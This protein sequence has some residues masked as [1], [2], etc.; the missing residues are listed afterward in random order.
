MIDKL[1]GIVSPHIC[2]GCKEKGNTLCDSC[3]FNIIDDSYQKCIACGGLAK[4]GNLCQKCHSKMPFDRA[5]V[6]GERR[7]ELKRLVG[8]FKYNSER[9]GA[10]SVAKLLDGV[11]PALPHGTVIVPIPTIAPHIRQRGF[12]HMELV[13]RKL[14]RIRKMSY[15]SRLLIRIDNSV[16]HGLTLR[17]REKRAAKTFGVNRH[18]SAPSEVLLIDDIY[19]SGHTMIAATKLLKKA[20]VKTVNVAIVAK[21]VGKDK[22]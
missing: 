17:E 5:F 8:D 19:T 3:I 10:I 9:A 6:V 4:T 15:D 11:L 7:D 16:Q 12:G 18:R 2:K 21:Q 13:A 1:L 20:G 22:R 14:A